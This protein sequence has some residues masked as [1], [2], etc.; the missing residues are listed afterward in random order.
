MKIK[1]IIAL[2]SVLSIAII[3]NYTGRNIRHFVEY[4]F[5]YS[6]GLNE[7]DDFTK[8]DPSEFMESAVIEEYGDEEAVIE[9]YVGEEYGN[10][11]V[12]EIKKED[13]PNGWW[14]GYHEGYENAQRKTSSGIVIEKTDPVFEKHYLFES[15]EYEEFETGYNIGWLDG[16]DDGEE[17]FDSKR[18]ET[19]KK[20]SIAKKE[21][22]KAENSNSNMEKSSD[23]AVKDI[24]M[25]FLDNATEKFACDYCGKESDGIHKYVINW[26]NEVEDIGVQVW[27]DE[28]F[29][30]KS[31]GQKYKNL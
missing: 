20:E 15:E 26:D 8:V 1:I 11:E 16:K 3:D 18:K 9:E 24:I 10:A 30:K 2:L 19:N 22:D 27:T 13:D 21:L 6:N 25:L 5:D 31:C 23:D 12:D 28:R 29:C 4:L 7:D 17:E 14:L